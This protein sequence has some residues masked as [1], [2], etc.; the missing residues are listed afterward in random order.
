MEGKVVVH[1]VKQ[2]GLA[3]SI[4]MTLWFGKIPYEN[5]FLP[6][7]AKEPE[8]WAEVKKTL[9]FEFGSMPMLE[10]DGMKLVESNAILAYLAEKIGIVPASLKERYLANS[11]F[12][13]LRD[14]MQGMIP[15]F[16]APPEG[17]IAALEKWLPNLDAKLGYYEGRLKA[18]ETQDFLVGKSITITDIMAMNIYFSFFTRL[19]GNA[20]HI[21]KVKEVLEK[22]PLYLEYVNKI[23]DNH[24]KEYFENVRFEPEVWF[25]IPIDQSEFLLRWWAA[26]KLSNMNNSSNPRTPLP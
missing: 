11:A 16:Y 9:G 24:F 20:E 3:E 8:K 4:R 14:T 7:P 6:R 18:N 21:A 17:K 5:N 12:E 1:Y 19:D 23:K 2:F 26:F 25:W 10:I 15:F 22:H 13:L